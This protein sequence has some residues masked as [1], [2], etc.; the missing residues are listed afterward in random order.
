MMNLSLTFKFFSMEKQRSWLPVIIGVAGL[1]IGAG[2]TFTVM[3]LYG[4]N[5]LVTDPCPSTLTEKQ[6]SSYM[7]TYLST[8]APSQGILG[9]F[10]VDLQQ[11]NAMACLLT[12]NSQ[13]A[14]F[15]MYNGKDNTGAIISMLVGVD[16]LTNDD[17]TMFYTVNPGISGPCPPICDKSPY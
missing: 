1:L 10:T 9:G 16:K 13:L 8:A 12:H 2:I 4:Q 5:Y 17:R 11:Y 14:G 7:K 15:R 6:V 3:H